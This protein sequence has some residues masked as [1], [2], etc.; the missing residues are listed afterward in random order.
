MLRKAML[1]LKIVESIEPRVV[2]DQGDRK[3][4]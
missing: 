3:L 1:Y 2:V 4:K